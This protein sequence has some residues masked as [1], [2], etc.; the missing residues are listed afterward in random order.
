MGLASIGGGG[1]GLN[2]CYVF[3]GGGGQNIITCLTDLLAGYCI[4]L[5]NIAAT[6]H[7]FLHVYTQK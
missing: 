3:W 6:P 4:Y 5:K 2:K 7:F 1:G